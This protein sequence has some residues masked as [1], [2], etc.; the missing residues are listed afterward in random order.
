MSFRLARILS[1]ALLGLCAVA[2]VHADPA[3]KT[4]STKKAA[5][6][7]K[8]ALVWRGDVATA[9]GIIIDVAKA[10]EKA[11]KGKIDVQPFNTAS[12]LD[13]VAMGTA[14]FAGS[15]RGA[16]TAAESNLVFTPVAW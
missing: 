11:G 2:T 5:Q 3:A 6:P 1:V 8:P 9:R 7:A 13:A 10:Y 14:D 4:K 15:A 16:D 12:G